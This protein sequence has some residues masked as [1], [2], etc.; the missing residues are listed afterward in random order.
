MAD[1]LVDI[2]KRAGTDDTV[3]GGSRQAQS[4]QKPPET[5][6]HLHL[7]CKATRAA[8]AVVVAWMFF[9]VI[10]DP[11]FAAYWMLL[12]VVILASARELCGGTQVVPRQEASRD[13]WTSNRKEGKRR[14]W[15][16]AILALCGNLFALTTLQDFEIDL[17]HYYHHIPS[18]P[19]DAD[20]AIQFFR[21]YNPE[22]SY[23]SSIE[24][25]HEPTL[26][27]SCVSRR[28]LRSRISSI[29]RRIGHW[30]RSTSASC[31]R[32]QKLLGGRG[33]GSSSCG[34]CTQSATAAWYISICFSHLC[35][36]G[37]HFTGI[38]TTAAPTT[39]VTASTFTSL[40]RRPLALKLR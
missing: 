36:I 30:R 17:E 38:C 20:Q 22:L 29:T 33:G 19:L 3:G 40:V 37:W 9:A 14:V 27:R 12:N 10:L 26:L 8:V 16:L 5:S 1:W 34:F 6:K 31:A 35:A 13:S 15:C 11:P 18:I 39:T 28:R 24:T 25:I 7:P 4:P 2:R 23:M 32:R 21:I